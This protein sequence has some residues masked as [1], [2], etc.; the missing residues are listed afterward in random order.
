[1]AKSTTLKSYISND[2]KNGYHKLLNKMVKHGYLIDEMQSMKLD[3]IL[4]D[5]RYIIDNDNDYPHLEKI[6]DGG[7]YYDSKSSCDIKCN[8]MDAIKYVASKFNTVILNHMNPYS[9]DEANDRIAR[10]IL[11]EVIVKFRSLQK[12]YDSRFKSAVE[13]ITGNRDKRDLVIDK[14]IEML[15]QTSYI[16]RWL[17]NRVISRDIYHD[18]YERLSEV[19]PWKASIKIHV[20]YIIE[21]LLYQIQLFV[22]REMKDKDLE[23]N[24][25]DIYD[26]ERI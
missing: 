25:T 4:D 23:R 7:T 15:E 26:D 11:N 18:S 9:N 3:I 14:T 5:L 20:E 16:N 17:L 19:I 22:V 6:L 24:L 13:W 21:R 10:H 8:Q 2:S 1:M 12:K